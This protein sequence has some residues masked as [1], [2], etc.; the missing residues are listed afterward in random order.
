M[1]ILRE[2][3]DSM[4]PAVVAQIDARLDGIRAEAVIPLAIESGSRAWGFA[5]PDSDYDCRFLY[6]RPIDDYLS[7]WPKRDVIETPLDAV[8]DVNGWD[9]AKALPLLL[10]GNA[11]VIEWLTSPIRY[12][13]D[14]WF[15]DAMLAFA[16]AHVPTDRLERHYLHLGLRQWARHGRRDAEIPLKRL[17]YALRPAAALRW[18]RLQGGAGVPPMAFGTLMAQCDPPVGM[19]RQVAELI[20]A[21]TVTRELGSGRIPIAVAQFIDAEYA[22]AIDRAKRAPPAVPDIGAAQEAASRL[23]RAIVRRYDGSP[24]F[25]ESRARPIG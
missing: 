20:A 2:I 12:A 23:F 1:S 4:D 25:P 18:L 13:A 8:L 11:V 10:K 7:P 6:V 19:A 17:F 3:P 14:P 21:K 22:I 24:V 5:S 15:L 16:A 9:I